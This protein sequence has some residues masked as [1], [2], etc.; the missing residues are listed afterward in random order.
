MRADIVKL[1][2]KLSQEYG[3]WISGDDRLDTEEGVL[4]AAGMVLDRIYEELLDTVR[5]LDNR[6]QVMSAL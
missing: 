1:R 6:K 2:Q 4:L 5:E 3:G